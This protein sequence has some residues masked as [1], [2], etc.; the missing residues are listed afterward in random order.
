[1]LKLSEISFSITCSKTLLTALAQNKWG[2][3]ASTWVN[4][5]FY[6]ASN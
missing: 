3:F 2:V 6:K 5:K 4:I 1:M